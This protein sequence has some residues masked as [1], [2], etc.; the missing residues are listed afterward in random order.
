MPGV[1]M[2]E[3]LRQ[4]ADEVTTALTG[5]FPGWTVT[6][7]PMR[8]LTFNL[9]DTFAPWEH[10]A[11]VSDGMVNFSHDRVSLS[12]KDATYLAV[13]LDACQLYVLVVSSVDQAELKEKISE[14]WLT[15]P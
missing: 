3:L 12:V 1:Q 15:P 11:F 2:E 7:N 13:E 14:T 6:V 9:R 8:G 5:M 10:G 4:T